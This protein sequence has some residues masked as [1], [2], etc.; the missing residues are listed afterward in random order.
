MSEGTWRRLLVAGIAAGSLHVL[1]FVGG[2]VERPPAHIHNGL[3][4]VLL[5]RPADAARH[6]GRAAPQASLPPG[7]EAR[8][9]DGRRHRAVARPAKPVRVA[10]ATPAKS[11]LATRRMRETP[12]RA[13]GSP[14]DGAE[15]A[16]VSRIVRRSPVR[17]S[18]PQAAGSLPASARR[19]LLAHITYPPMA[20]RLGW[21]GAGLFRLDVQRRRI[22]RVSA[23]ASTGYRLL[24]R[25]VLN[26]LR[27]V[28][29]LDIADGRYRLPVEF[30]LQ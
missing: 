8:K 2:P 24:D 28:P 3:L 18:T 21:Q 1:L 29:E 17:A 26:G 14:R 7:R 30:R 12:E 25:A 23:L 27:D 5:V 16:A 13:S 6:A 9:P 11:Q 22:V 15:P 4:Q 19:M 10:S 20:R